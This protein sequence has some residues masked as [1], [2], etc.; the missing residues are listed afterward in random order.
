MNNSSMYLHQSPFRPS[1][2]R[3]SA[4]ACAAAAAARARRA[5]GGGG[6]ATLRYLWEM[7]GSLNCVTSMEFW[8]AVKYW[9]RVARMFLHESQQSVKPY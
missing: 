1:G 3:V 7:C 9:E 6:S 4:A 2:A 5:R 8:L